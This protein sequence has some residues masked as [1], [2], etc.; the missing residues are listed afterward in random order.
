MRIK[1]QGSHIGTKELQEMGRC[2]CAGLVKLDNNCSVT[3]L[4][5][6]IPKLTMDEREAGEDIL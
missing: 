2:F 5:G 4:L 1:F 6:T 3:S